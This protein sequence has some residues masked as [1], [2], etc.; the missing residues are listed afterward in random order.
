MIDR[1]FDLEI[2]ILHM[3]EEKLHSLANVVCLGGELAV[4]TES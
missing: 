1:W 2:L 4:D 3:L